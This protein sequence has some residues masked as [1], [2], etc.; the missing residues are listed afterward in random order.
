MSFSS[1]WL[2]LRELGASGCF[3]VGQISKWR[4]GFVL[5]S[6]VVAKTGLASVTVLRS[7]K[8]YGQ[9]SRVFLSLLENKNQRGFSVLLEL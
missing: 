8:F 6:K 3:L 9:D 2:Q 7:F 5:S 4:C 1:P